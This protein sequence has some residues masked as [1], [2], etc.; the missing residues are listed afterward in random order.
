MSIRLLAGFALAV[1]ATLSA[2]VPALANRFGPPWQARVAT[3]ALIV[4]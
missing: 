4:K 2:T 3:P 1:V